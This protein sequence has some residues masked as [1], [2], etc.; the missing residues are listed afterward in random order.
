M[1][2]ITS[3][4]Y[5][6]GT[7]VTIYAGRVALP[8]WLTNKP[9]NELFAIA[10][11]EGAGST[12]TARS[13]E[14]WGG[15]ALRV[16]SSDL[17]L[18]AAGGHADGTNNSVIRLRLTDPAPAWDVR[19]APSSVPNTDGTNFGYDA[20]GKP[21]ARHIYG[22]NHHDAASD[23]IMLIGARYV[24]GTGPPSFEN[25][26]GWNCQTEVWDAKDTYPIIGPTRATEGAG[27]GHLFDSTNGIAITGGG[28]KY[29]TATKAIAQK[30]FTGGGGLG[31]FPGAFDSTRGKL[32]S[33]QWGDGQGFNSGVSASSI[34]AV[35]ETSV[36]ITFNASAAY[37]QFVSDAPTYAGMTYSADTDKFYFYAPFSGLYRIYVITPNAST[38]WDMSI[39]TL[40]GGSATLPAAVN[41]GVNSRFKYVPALKVL[42]LQVSGASPVYALRT[43]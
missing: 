3:D 27:F 14:A 13:V 9:L 6:V 38:V 40:G 21:S 18:A 12:I 25:I 5:S 10:G 26:D 11:T 31:R 34:D 20:D 23:R 39:L 28:Y 41:A 24:T 22:N 1:P 7:G 33:L 35:A 8:A 4:S 36:A 2:T 29:I 43:S 15:W 17:Y 19:C 16:A 42:V 37:T 30:S 32:F